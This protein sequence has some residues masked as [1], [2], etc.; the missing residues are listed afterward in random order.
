MSKRSLLSTALAGC[1]LLMVGGCQVQPPTGPSIAVMPGA[2]KSFPAFQQDD[3]TCR[4]YAQSRTNNGSAQAATNGTLATTAGTTLLGTAAGALLGAAG[5]NAG[6]GAAIGA[7]AG[8]LGGAAIAGNQGGN[9]QMSLQEQYD[10]A[11]AQC[12]KAKG[13]DVPP[14]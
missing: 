10:I 5:G 11:Y 14:L 7:G 2:G 9:A 12:M 6:A 8:L 4:G 13:N 3:Y 1:A